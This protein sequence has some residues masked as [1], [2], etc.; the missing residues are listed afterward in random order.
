VA[1]SSVEG[2]GLHAGAGLTGNGWFSLIKEFRPD[3]YRVIDI[4]A[5]H[6]VRRLI[7][8]Q[9]L[10]LLARLGTAEIH[11][12]RHIEE[13]VGR[14]CVATDVSGEPTIRFLV[15]LKDRS[16]PVD[17]PT[18]YQLIRHCRFPRQERQQ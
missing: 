14:R 2:L 12:E 5:R 6:S 11:R 4:L 3:K 16:A 10:A 1:Q 17:H 8:H 13:L 7:N 9:L 15:A 18:D